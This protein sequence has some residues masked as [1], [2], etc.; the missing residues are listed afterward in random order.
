MTEK[1]GAM[2]GNVLV[3]PG[4]VRVTHWLNA[5]GILIMVGSGWRIYNNVPI[6]SFV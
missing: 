6:F 3:H 2:P 4:I 5:I 1:N